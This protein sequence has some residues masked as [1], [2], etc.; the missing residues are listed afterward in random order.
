MMANNETGAINKIAEITRLVKAKDA[1]CIVHTD[2]SQAVGKIPVDV[3][4]LG[5]DLLTIAAHKLYGP[6]GIGALFIRNGTRINR[7]CDGGGQEHG[8]RAGTEN[9]LLAVG[10]GAA[11]EAAMETCLKRT[12]DTL[13]LKREFLSKLKAH[14]PNLIVNGPLIDSGNCLP[15]ALSVSVPNQQ[16]HVL[17]TLAAD[18]GVCFSAGAACHAHDMP[19]P[20]R[21]LMAMPGMTEA[22]ALGTIRLSI[23]RYTT[24]EDVDWASKVIV[25]ALD[26]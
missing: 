15:G 12:E 7:F 14:V 19:T 22:R 16:G 11:C 25:S 8:R 17:C 9:V 23:G 6:K 13:S 1:I 20:S 3:D 2:A 10:F 26:V 4:A 24:A 5:V 18:K 21:V